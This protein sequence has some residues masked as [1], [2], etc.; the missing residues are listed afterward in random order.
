VPG[1]GPRLHC[2]LDR[3]AQRSG[4]CETAP[5]AGSL[6][7]RIRLPRPRLKRAVKRSSGGPILVL[8]EPTRIAVAWRPVSSCPSSGRRGSSSQDPA[9]S[10][11]WVWGSRGRPPAP[12]RRERVTG[13]TQ[14]R[15]T[16]VSPG[17]GHLRP[18]SSDG[19]ELPRSP[20]L[21]Y[22]RRSQDEPA[23]GMNERFAIVG[24]AGS[25]RCLHTAGPVRRM[26]SAL[27]LPCIVPRSHKR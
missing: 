26:R 27:R 17:A 23:G 15:A 9:P 5:G 2:L 21:C 16:D 24:T 10:G 4:P 22:Y 11:P 13:L 18:S 19:R 7:R 12:F 1:V 3:R 20:P 6:V 25:R 8:R 14:A